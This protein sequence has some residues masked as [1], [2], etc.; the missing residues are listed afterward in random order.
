[1]DIKGKNVFLTGGN[2]GMGHCIAMDL[3]K[4]GANVAFGYFDFEEKASEVEKELQSMGVKA[5]KYYINISNEQSVI[6]TLKEVE[7]DFN[8]LS[9]LINVAGMTYVIDHKDLY[10]MKSEYWD[11]IWSVNVKGTFFVCRE[12]KRLLDKNKK[13][14]IVNITSTAGM[15]GKG[16][17]IAY[18]ASKAAEINMTRSLARAFAPNIRVCSVAPGLV[19]TNFTKDM[20]AARFEKLAG[21]TCIQRLVVPEEVA[22]VVG[23]L[24]YD[25]DILT[26]ITIAADGGR[27]F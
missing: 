11:Q 22:A 5:K 6:N 7:N 10:A 23:S 9:A 16:S 27:Q 25:N 20:D 15:N 17:C 26:G 24:I 3:A 18:A 13:A 2:T 8:D 14:C 1:M 19:Q 21:E 4:H 12:A